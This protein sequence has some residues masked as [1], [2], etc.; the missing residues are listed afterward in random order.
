MRR[1]LRSIAIVAMFCCSPAAA[2]AAPALPSGTGAHAECSTCH[3]TDSA[4]GAVPK[5]PGER[6]VGCHVGYAVAGSDAA[7]THL[8]FGCTGCHDP[9]ATAVPFRFRRDRQSMVPAVAG[10]DAETR[11]C[12]A[13]HTGFAEARGMAG[14]Y[15]RHPVG[16]AVARHGA[17]VIAA[18]GRPVHDIGMLPLVRGTT[19]AG[20][21][22]D[23]VGCGTCHHVHGNPNPR[24]LRWAPDRESDACLGCHAEAVG[25]PVFAGE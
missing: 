22:A 1:P 23:V 15:V 19:T 11:L 25:A 6:C 24:L 13:C 4:P 20:Y 17:N 2:V 12:V 10:L 14:A 8:G 3:T 7:G 16:V 18:N 9:H 5:P 21:E